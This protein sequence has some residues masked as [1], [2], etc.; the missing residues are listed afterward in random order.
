MGMALV[1]L[2]MMMTNTKTL[3]TIN[4][5]GAVVCMIYGILTNTWPTALL[6]FGLGIIQTVQLIR[7]N[8]KKD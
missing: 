5:A 3:R 6:N 2:S 1:L 7:M 8:K 4:L